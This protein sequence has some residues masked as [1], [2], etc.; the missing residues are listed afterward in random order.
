MVETWIAARADFFV[1][2]VESRSPKPSSIMLFYGLFGRCFYIDAISGDAGSRCPSSSSAA[3]W[4][5][6]TEA[7]RRSSVRSTPRSPALLPRAALKAL[8]KKA[9]TSQ[10]PAHAQRGSPRAV[11]MKALRI[12]R[13]AAASPRLR[14]EI[15]ALGRRLARRRQSASHASRI[16]IKAV[17]ATSKLSRPGCAPHGT[18]HGCA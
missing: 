18:P 12:S 9:W 3:S 13:L 5:S 4:A 14:A 15:V 7:P 6:L 10:V 8:L 16:W 1:G 17:L 2:T 11:H